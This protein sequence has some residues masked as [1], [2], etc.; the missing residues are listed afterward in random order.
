MTR[1]I[2]SLFLFLLIAQTASAQVTPVGNEPGAAPTATA[3]HISF[4]SIPA[5]ARGETASVFSAQL[6]PQRPAPV[7][8]PVLNFSAQRRRGSFVGYIDDPVV[9]SKV[10]V[11]FEM[12]LHSSV[13]DRAEFFYAKCGC[14][15][16]LP[17]NDPAFDPNAKGPFSDIVGDLNFQQFYVFAEYAATER[18]SAFAEL[19]LRW[20]QPQ[21][22]SGLVNQSGVSDLRAG[23][24]FG[25]ATNEQMSLT[26]Q[27]KTFLQSGDSRNGLGT[28]H[29]SVEPGLLYHRNLSDRAAIA[30]Q[31]SLWIPFGG[32]DGVPTTV[33]GK[34]AGSVLSYGIGPSIEVYSS[35]N[36]SFA[37]VVELVGWRVL[38]GYQTTTPSEAGGTNIVNIK[39]G[40]RATWAN[41]TSIYGGYGKALTDAD[42]Y[43]DIL[44]FE[45]RWSF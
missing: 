35:E 16:G 25:L 34:F 39:F 2:L 41:G 27:V 43:D 33:D 29:A 12:G 31:V 10:R 11:R 42:W 1:S 7:P 8:A 18:F 17:S 30:T 21:T 19:P 26:A 44:R 3:R 6:G 28:G 20:I 32:S 37:P 13:P 4:A 22:P 14:Y 36:V 23:V 5:A 24:K 40:A 38:N 45:Y 9:S 15:R